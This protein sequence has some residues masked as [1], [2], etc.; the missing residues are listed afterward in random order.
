M[1]EREMENQSFTPER[2]ETIDLKKLFEKLVEHW[3]WFVVAIPAGAV[4]AWCYCM[5]QEPVYDVVSKVMVNDSKKGDIGTNLVMQELGFVQGDM[6]VE[7]EMIEL[8]SK[9]LIREVVQ[10]MSLNIRYFRNGFLRDQ[11]MYG[12]SPVRLR[13]NF[14]E[15]IADTCVHLI[16]DSEEKIILQDPDGNEIGKYGFSEEIPFDDYSFTI[17]KNAGGD[18]DEIIVFLNSDYTATRYFAK[19]LSV[20]SIEKNTNAIRVAIKD[21]LPERGKAFIR[22]LID[23]Y[24][25]NGIKDKQLV[26]GKTVEFI[27]SRLDV[28]NGELGNIEDDA[29]DFKRKNKLTDIASDAAYE[30]ERKKMAGSELLKLQMELDVVKGIHSLLDKTPENEFNLLPE[31]LGI[32]DEGLNSGI[33][34]YNEMLL[35]R[36]KLL[37]SA[38]ENN[39]IVQ[40]LDVQLRELKESVRAA[41][42]QV[43]RGLNIKI[44][45][46]E[47]ENRL[48]DERLI[49]VPTQE[50]EYRAIAR[51]Q[52]L[53]EKLFLFLMQKREETEIAK[54][55]Y[56]AKAKIIEDPDAGVGPV[57]P[58]KAL[59]LLLGLILGGAIPVGIVLGKDMFDSKIRGV[60]DVESSVTIPVLGTFP[61][62]KEGETAVGNDDF[63]QLESMHLVR[64]KLNY[65]VDRDS[66]PVI[67]V[68]STISS[69]GK[70]LIASR[71][72]YAYAGSGKK[73][74]LVGCDLRNPSLHNYLKC[75]TSKGLSSY[76]AGMENDVDKLIVHVEEGLDVLVGGVVPPNP[77]QLLSGM[78]MKELL[79]ALK[80]RYECIILDTPPVGLL[81][82]GFA[83]SKLADACVYVIRADVSRKDSLSFLAGLKR[84]GRLPETGI[85][86]NGISLH[87]RRYGYGYG[88]GYG[89][90]YH[91]A[92]KQKDV[93]TSK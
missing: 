36:N 84:E 4:L 53:K 30:M 35:K 21:N 1:T 66:C 85:V 32:T 75:F 22:T 58:K 54:L 76:L 80:K 18:W 50:K 59:I 60:E 64:E 78:R 72:A 61:A 79:E 20:A 70:S 92:S 51:Q 83:L 56:I 49:S 27:N 13:V 45:S 71:L 68:T 44:E 73:V 48:V 62:L 34:R 15:L 86:V 19:N 24:N 82:E 42:V 43:E 69:E 77:V 39:P 12:N 41:V 2:E 65:F 55:M 87:K 14:P 33:S 16:R 25:T 17:E 93:K 6:F 47:R 46:V 37:L 74:L 63:V 31:N 28:I 3:K 52:E 8:Q 89:S 67:M 81:A 91:Y 23:C 26:S 9:N 7:N 88:Y 5:L 40:G 10:T 38:N 90:N 29:E 57:A 11:E